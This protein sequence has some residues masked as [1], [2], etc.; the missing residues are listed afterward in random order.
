MK[1][2]F[3]ALTPG[4]D[5]GAGSYD[6]GVEEVGEGEGVADKVTYQIEVRR[7]PDLLQEYDVIFRGALQFRGMQCLIKAH[8]K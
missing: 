7:P 4:E 2:S 6:A 5:A 1:T 3:I 8:L